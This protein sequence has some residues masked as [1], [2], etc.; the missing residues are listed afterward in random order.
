MFGKLFI[1]SMLLV[2]TLM[3]LDARAEGGS[4]AGHMIDPGASIGRSPGS[5]GEFGHNDIES[6][7]SD[8]EMRHMKRRQQVF[9]DT[10]RQEG[11]R[12]QPDDLLPKA[13]AFRL[14]GR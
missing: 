2:N 8:A 1:L 9:S 12:R 13:A 10:R 4:I 3:V 5:V 14:Q 7:N 11:I 6:E